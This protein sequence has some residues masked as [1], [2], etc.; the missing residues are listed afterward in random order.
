VQQVINA[1]Y[2]AFHEGLRSAL[3]LS[4]L[5]VLLAGLFAVV[6]LGRHARR[7]AS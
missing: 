5:L 6:A 7:Q 2:T 3:Y 4:A 1:A